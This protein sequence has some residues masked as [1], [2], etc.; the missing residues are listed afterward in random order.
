MGNLFVRIIGGNS[1]HWR[2][3]KDPKFYRPTTFTR[4]FNFLMINEQDYLFAPT[5]RIVKVKSIPELEH[6]IFSCDQTRLEGRLHDNTARCEWPPLETHSRCLLPLKQNGRFGTKLRIV[7]FAL[8][9][10]CNYTNNT[11]HSTHH[12]LANQ[13]N[14]HTDAED[15]THLARHENSTYFFV[16]TKWNQST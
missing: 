12:Q 15:S 8:Q 2:K 13:T 11:L 10:V 1:K 4:N 14:A 5:H 6:C 7:S 3:K 16:I 9:V